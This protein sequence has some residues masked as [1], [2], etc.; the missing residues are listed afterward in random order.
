VGDKIIVQVGDALVLGLV[1]NKLK[2]MSFSTH[3]KNLQ[4]HVK[5]FAHSAHPRMEYVI[6]ENR[7]DNECHIIQR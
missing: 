6:P 4:Y 2:R 7:K 3:F 1:V 5:H